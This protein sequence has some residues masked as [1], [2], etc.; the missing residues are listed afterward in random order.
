MNKNKMPNSGWAAGL[1]PLQVSTAQ[2]PIVIAIMIV[3]LI[4]SATFVLPEG[5]V[6]VAITAL[7]LAYRR[8]WL[9]FVQVGVAF[10]LISISE[11]FFDNS[12]PYVAVD[13][14]FLPNVLLPCMTAKWVSRM[15]MQPDGSHGPS[16]ESIIKTVVFVSLLFAATVGIFSLVN[17]CEPYHRY[18]ALRPYGVRLV[19]ILLLLG[20]GFVLADQVLRLFEF[21]SASQQQ[22]RMYLLQLCYK[23]TRSEGR[24]LFR[25]K[26]RRKDHK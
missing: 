15:I 18:V 8:L 13:Y 2:W 6:I 20:A 14:V 4:T 10:Y 11:L 3:S 16:W 1:R 7:A 25:R 9:V 21:S 12:A 24:L 23:E 19:A 22:K 5:I 17:S 26:R